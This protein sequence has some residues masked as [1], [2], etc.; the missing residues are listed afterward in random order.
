M[1]AGIIIGLAGPIGAGK[2][3]VADI[4]IS[5]YGFHYLGFGCLVKQTLKQEGK[6]ITRKNLQE[7]GKLIIKQ[8]GYKGIVD[9]LLEN[10]DTAT[11]YVIDGIRH[12]EVVNYL[13]QLYDPSFCLIFVDAPTEVRFKRARERLQ[14]ENIATIEKFKEYENDPLE[15][16]V[17]LLKKVASLAV[18]NMRSKNHLKE[19]IKK[20]LG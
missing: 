1:K 14:Y 13:K 17:A 11:N 12:I 4:L 15:K 9:L 10:T 18:S 16:D 7:K 8:V 20:F 5:Q 19:A 3:S 2:S 6:Q